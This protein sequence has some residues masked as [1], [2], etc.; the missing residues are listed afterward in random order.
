MRE[1]ARTHSTLHHEPSINA[2]DSRATCTQPLGHMPSTYSGAGDLWAIVLA[3]GEGRRLLPL[4]RRLYGE[5]R[6]K[7]YAAL[8]RSTSLLRQTLERV[9]LVTRP[10]RTVVTTMASH[11]AYL[12]AELAGFAGIDVLAQPVD[13]GTA[14]G[15]L[16]PAH[17]IAAR[18]P[19]ATVA[20]FPTDHFVRDEA[21]SMRQVASVAGYVQAHPEWLVLLGAQPSEPDADYGWIEPGARVGSA[22][23]WPLCQIHRFLEKPAPEEARRLFARGGLWNTFV[24]ASS[25]GTLIEAGLECVPVLHDRLVRLGLYLG[26]QHEAWALR[27]AYEFAP[28]ADFSRAILESCSA[29][30]AVA[31]IPALT[32]CDLGTQ[33]RVARALGTLHSPASWPAGIRRRA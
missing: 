15:I 4:T 23:G 5:E 22:D 33:D 19:R 18:D 16:L 11:A 30:F 14:A 2:R 6:P 20:V 12:D 25:V 9:A 10:E 32:W 7:Q 26:T 8:G 21:A 24:F 1:A 31:P 3:G 29:S 13:R 27:Q 17:W 28:T